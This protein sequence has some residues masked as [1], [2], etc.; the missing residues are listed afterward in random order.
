MIGD[1]LTKIDPNGEVSPNLASSWETPD[2]GKTWI[3]HLKPGNLWQD[4]KEVLAK[5]INYNFKD[6]TVERPDD[7][8]LVFKL[9]DPYSAFPSVVAKP[10][11]KRGLLGTGEWEV[12]KIELAGNFVGQLQLQNKK[13]NKIIYKFYP[14]EERLKLAFKLGEV[15]TMWELIDPTPISTWKGVKIEEKVDYGKYIGVFLNTQD[16]SLSEKTF[17]QALAYAIDKQKLSGNR[18]ISPISQESWAFNSQVKPYNFDPEKAKSEIKQGS[19]ISLTTSPLL[20]PVAEMIKTDWE[21]AGMK[22]NLQVL[23]TIPTEYQALLA[24][25]DIPEDPDQYSIWHSTQTSTNI[26]KY[27]NPRIDKLLEDG[28]AEV[29]LEGRREI[30]LDFQRFLVEDSPT[31]FLYYPTTYT[32]TR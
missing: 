3:F 19:E 4:E 17:R 13:K 8:T 12:K 24:I 11:F 25:F 26:T 14:T 9:N 6:L 27:S 23:S 15:S 10:I 1:G 30:Y 5:D 32:I 18:A 20:L 22:V 2:K 28:R 7:S 31:L 21:N 29:N 16:S